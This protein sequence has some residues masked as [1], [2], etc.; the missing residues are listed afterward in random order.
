MYEHVLAAASQYGCTVERNADMK[1][2]TSFKIGGPAEILIKPNSVDALSALLKGCKQDGIRPLVLGRGSNVLVPDEGLRGVVF[3][4]GD[5]FAK[6]EYAGNNMV[7]AQAGASLMRLCRFA[8]EYKLGGLE[9]AYGIPGSVGGAVYMNAGAYGMEIRDVLVC[10]DLLSPETG[11]EFTLSRDELDL[12]YRHSRL[13][14]VPYIVTRVRLQL[15]EEDPERIQA[16]MRELAAL[17]REKQPLS[18][19]SAGSTF[20]RPEGSFAAKLID[21][22]GLRGLQIGDAQVSEKHAGFIINRGHATAADI[23]ALIETVR[24]RVFEE[25]GITLEPEVRILGEDSVPAQ[26]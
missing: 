10:A 5:D 11:E 20:K 8:L 6:I 3:V 25:T 24:G 15:Y 22:C 12:S 14:E 23:L 1:Q 2:Y 17:R 9:F 19:P 13:M 4:M 26:C 21:E 16:R 7:K 18:Y